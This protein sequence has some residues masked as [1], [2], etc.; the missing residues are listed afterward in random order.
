MRYVFKGEDAMPDGD[1]VRK[2]LARKYHR[3]YKE[4][5]A[6]KS[7]DEELAVGVVSPTVEQIK[8]YGDEALQFLAEIV[9]ICKDMQ[10]DMP[11]FSRQ[12]D[13]HRLWDK[14]RESRTRNVYGQKS[15]TSCLASLQRAD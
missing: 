4:I 6:G 3:A 15:Q 12:V 10:V 5:C 11:L 13:W 14:N 1:N 7:E 2:R 8:E 9:H